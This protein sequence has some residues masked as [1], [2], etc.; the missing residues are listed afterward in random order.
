MYFNIG[1]IRPAHTCL[2]DGCER[3]CLHVSPRAGDVDTKGSA[4]SLLLTTVPF[5]FKSVTSPFRGMV[6]LRTLSSLVRRTTPKRP[7]TPPAFR[8]GISP[9][10]A[11]NT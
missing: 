9:V 8:V 10:P 4:F 2:F 11:V 5:V 7:L 6:R 3:L 1:M